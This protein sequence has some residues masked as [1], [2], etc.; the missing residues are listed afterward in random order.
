MFEIE[1]AILLNTNDLIF[2]SVYHTAI[3]SSLYLYERRYLAGGTVLELPILPVVFL[4]I[5]VMANLYD[6]GSHQVQYI[7]LY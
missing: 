1:R 5:E 7:I 4:F 3:I 2:I 6:I